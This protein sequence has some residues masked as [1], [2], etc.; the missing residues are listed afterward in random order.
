MIL[1]EAVQP[2]PI[3]I[4]YTPQTRPLAP[5]TKGFLWQFG[6]SFGQEGFS[7]RF[8]YEFLI[9]EGDEEYWMPVQEPHHDF[10]ANKLTAGQTATIY[11]RLL[12]SL[13]TEEGDRMIFIITDIKE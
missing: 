6:E 1:L 4:G 7:A 13:Q 2:E 5:E 12:G 9:R 10:L 3:P 11:V 8:E